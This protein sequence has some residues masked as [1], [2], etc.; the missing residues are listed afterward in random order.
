MIYLDHNAT[1]PVDADVREAMIDCLSDQFGNPSSLHGLGRKARKILEDSREK[2]SQT[3]G[4]SEDELFFTSGGTESINLALRGSLQKIDPGLLK[5][6]KPHIIT[7]A[8]EH[9]AV[10][11]TLEE[12]KKEGR[13][14]VTLVGVDSKGRVKLEDFQKALRP[15]TFLISMMW[16]NNEIG[17]IYPIEAIG[18]WVRSQKILFHVDAVQALGKLEIN[19]SKIPVDLMSLSAHKIYGPKGVGALYILSGVKVASCHTGGAQEMEKR[20]G[21][22]NLPG[23]VGFA[24]AVEKIDLKNDNSR[25]KI[26]RQKLES[27]LA[28]IPQ[29]H[30]Q[31]DEGSRVANTLSMTFEG[32]ES[33]MGIIALDREGIAVS[34]GSACASG[35]VE[36]SHVLLAMGVNRGEAKGVIRFSLGKSTTESEIETVLKSFLK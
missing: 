7:T 27:G 24:Q 12:L 20:G 17:N 21:T 33:E 23:I 31:G 5:L 9:K 3:I 34:S 29:S 28:Q 13:L 1:T 35:A 32:V 15:T 18:H 8:V 19:L 36:P 30:V 25:I 14:E 4:A 10:L 2:I 11:E 6:G 16:V 22:E 26:L